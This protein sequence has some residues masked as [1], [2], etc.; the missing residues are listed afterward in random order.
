MQLDRLDDHS[1]DHLR[2]RFQVGC[3]L[4]YVRADQEGVP[5]GCTVCGQVGV[6]HLPAREHD[7]RTTAR[8]G[9][10]A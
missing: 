1:D 10:V 5:A 2:I 8:P 6:E 3:A 4:L 9:L 7:D